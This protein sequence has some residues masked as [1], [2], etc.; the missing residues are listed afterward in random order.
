MVEF[1]KLSITRTQD[2]ILFLNHSPSLTL[3]RWWSAPTGFHR[4][5]ISA[6]KCSVPL[7]S[8]FFLTC[9]CSCLLGPPASQGA[10]LLECR[11]C[12]CH[13]CTTHRPSFLPLHSVSPG[14]QVLLFPFLYSTLTHHTSAYTPT[15]PFFLFVLAVRVPRCTWPPCFVI[16]NISTINVLLIPLLSHL[17]SSSCICKFEVAVS[18]GAVVKH[19]QGR[20]G[21]SMWLTFSKRFVG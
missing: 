4:C 1:S 16:L 15:P 8:C 21:F 17:S 5:T 19:I 12:H 18:L 6:F 7:F 3:N 20:E 10:P 9:L 13:T 2:R 11:C 14:V